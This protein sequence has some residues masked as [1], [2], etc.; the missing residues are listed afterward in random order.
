MFAGK[1]VAELTA[2][3]IRAAAIGVLIYIGSHGYIGLPIGVL[4]GVILLVASWGLV[5]VLWLCLCTYALAATHP[6]VVPMAS[7]F[8]FV[9]T[10][11]C[12]F[13]GR[14]LTG[15]GI[16]GRILWRRPD[17]M[18]ILLSASICMAFVLPALRQ[19]RWWE[20]LPVA[21]SLFFLRLA[22]RTPSARRFREHV[23]NTLL[24]AAGLV[25]ALAIC[26]MGVR[27]SGVGNVMQLNNIRMF[28][29]V[30]GFMFRPGTSADIRRKEPNGK[31]STFHVAI[32]SQ[33][34]RDREYGARAPNE[35][36]ILMLGDSFAM[37]WA[38]ESEQSLPK[39]LERR[40]NDV[41]I[42]GKETVSVINGGVCNFGPWQERI[43]L[44][45]RGF[46]LEPNLVLHQVF[47]GNDIE[48]SLM[49]IGK[50]PK[51]YNEK[52]E[53]ETLRY[54]DMNTWPGRLEEVFHG[55]SALYRALL[56][57][58]DRGPLLSSFLRQFRFVAESPYGA[59]PCS[60]PRPCFMEVCL[61]E[62]YPLL[63][64]GWSCF[65]SDVSGIRADCHE[66]G[67][68][69]VGFCVPEMGDVNERQWY[70]TTRDLGPEAYER[71]KDV[72]LTEA[73]FRQEGIPCVSI[74]TLLENVERKT[75]AYLEG[76]GHL[77]SDGVQAVAN[78][79]AD[80]LIQR[81][82]GTGGTAAATSHTNTPTR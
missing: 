4:Y 68:D 28:H 45:E 74:R 77:S 21:G 56:H 76:D 9:V 8:F 66:R 47:P 22:C 34:L 58:Y 64:Q 25:V 75:P 12:Y 20:P 7:S 33:G 5:L 3:A 35:F 81:F 6:A 82:S 18:R 36:R 40:L 13:K 42:P 55:H 44:R 59:L 79:L 14:S 60:A 53:R 62:G 41:R 23:F 1:T 38:L 67:V 80:F 71:G 63:D 57:V 69:Y 51:A 37:G 26:E 10:F 70:E 78:A 50:V 30:A 65:E 73:Y 11:V 16:Y 46:P 48:N 39:V 72:R 32:S 17:I 31:T 49:R 29:P 61:R 43:L 27:V 19:I 2:V 52:A 15:G 24:F 54:L